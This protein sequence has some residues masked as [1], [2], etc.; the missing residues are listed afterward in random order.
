MTD[1]TRGLLIMVVAMLTLSPDALMLKLIAAEPL[2]MMFWRGLLMG[3][4]MAAIGLWQARTGLRAYWARFSVLTVVTAALFVS[5]NIGFLTAIHRTDAANALL[6]IAVAPLLAALI[7]RVFM[8]EALHRA[9]WVAVVVIVAALA[10]I[11]RDSAKFGDPVGDLAALAAAFGIAVFFCILRARPRVSNTQVFMVNGV[12]AMAIAYVF[13][14]PFALSGDQMRLVVPLCLVL[15]PVSAFLM[16]TAPRYLPAAEVSLL[17]LLESVF[18]PVLVWLGT[19]ELPT[20]TVMAAGAV[21][22]STLAAHTIVVSRS[23]RRARS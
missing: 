3:V 14:D 4:A 23:R 18:G 17:M 19:G 11:F 2:D 10:V 8:G 20:P 5:V 22:L 1:H 21:I 6:I 15:L 7:G 16:S 12:F 9:T 13:A